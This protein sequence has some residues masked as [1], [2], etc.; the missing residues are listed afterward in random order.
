MAPPAAANSSLGYCPT[1]L[2]SSLEARVKQH[3]RSTTARAASTDD[4]EVKS[5][6]AQSSLAV[7]LVERRRKV[8]V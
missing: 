5:A 2:E 6:T 8:I 3:E 4:N 7:A 1:Y